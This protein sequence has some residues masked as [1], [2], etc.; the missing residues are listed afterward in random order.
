MIVKVT[1]V[2]ED[3]PYNSE[4][5]NVHFISPWDLIVANTPWMQNVA[6]EWGNTSF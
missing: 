1:G 3:I 6:N 4:F 5:G 2:Y